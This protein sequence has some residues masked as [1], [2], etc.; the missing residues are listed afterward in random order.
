MKIVFEGTKE[1]RGWKYRQAKILVE[2]KQ[3]KKKNSNCSF[4]EEKNGQLKLNI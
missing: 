1:S 4:K 3:R 2:D